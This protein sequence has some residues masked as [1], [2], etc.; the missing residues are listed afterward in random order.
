MDSSILLER[1]YRLMNRY[2]A[3]QKQPRVYDGLVLHAAEAHMLEV[4]GSLPGITATALAAR[5]A[6]SKGAVSQTIRRLTEKGLI[7]REAGADARVARFTLTERGGQIRGQHRALHAPLL[8]ALERAL[9]ELS[10]EAGA[11]LTGL[12]DVLEDHLRQITGEEND[13]AD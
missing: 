6:V 4:I 2:Q 7:L 5:L 10:P 8:E 13:D 9:A 3:A 11:A 12:A 1:V